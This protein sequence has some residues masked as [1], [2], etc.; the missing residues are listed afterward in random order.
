[1]YQSAFNHDRWST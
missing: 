1:M